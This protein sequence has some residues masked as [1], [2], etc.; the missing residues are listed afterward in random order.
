LHRLNPVRIAYIRD[1]VTEHFGRDPH[2]PRPFEHLELLDVG[3]GGGLLSEPMARLG[4]SVTGIDAGEKTIRVA[5]VHARRLDL[6]IDYRCALPEDLVREGRSFDVVLNMEVV[7]HVADLDAFLEATARLL[8]PGGAMVVATLNRTLKSL[9]L[10]KIGAEYVLRWL[11]VGTHDW[12]K[13]V[14]PSELTAGLGRHRVDVLDLKGIAFNPL[15]D[16]WLL[17]RDVDVNYMVFGTKR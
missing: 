11:P 10:A 14:R 4:G 6:D 9:A 8:K 13:F 2:A 12:R 7:E 5:E 15:T 16:R 3:C 1:C 17:T